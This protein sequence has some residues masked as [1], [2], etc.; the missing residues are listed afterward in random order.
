MMSFSSDSEGK[1]ISTVR[2]RDK[3]PIAS[4]LYSSDASIGQ[5]DQSKLKSK[6][7]IMTEENMLLGQAQKS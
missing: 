2:K 7:I 6:K 4:D 1:K 5:S 3:R